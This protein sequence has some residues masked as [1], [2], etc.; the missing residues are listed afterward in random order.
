MMRIKEAIQRRK[1]IQQLNAEA[2]ADEAAVSP[3]GSAPKQGTTGVSTPV[4][5]AS[6]H[7]SRVSGMNR[8]SSD[9]ST[10]TDQQMANL[11]QFVAELSERLSHEQ[12]RALRVTWKRLCEPPKTSGRGTLKTMEKI[13]DLV[14]ESD[15]EVKSVFYRSAFLKCLMDRKGNIRSDTIATQRDHA[16]LLID[17]IDATI[18]IMFDNA[19]QKVVW[20]PISIGLAHANLIPLGFNRNVW[21][22]MGECFAEVMFSQECVRAYPHAASAWSM[23]SVACTDVMYTHSRLS[24][25]D[26]QS[27]LAQCT[28]RTVSTPC[29]PRIPRI[30]PPTPPSPSSRIAHRR[31]SHSNRLLMSPRSNRQWKLRRQS[32]GESVKSVDFEKSLK[33]LCNAVSLLDRHTDL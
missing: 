20:D 1:L 9:D 33:E 32:D 29:T 17:F 19:V 16:H 30:L 28:P 14:I 8:T 7:A 3:Y 27:Y 11:R 18:S 12:K 13:F 22:K 10:S 21:H 15:H 25:G 31:R 5:H 2:E 4:T 23:L 24:K 6:R 26:P